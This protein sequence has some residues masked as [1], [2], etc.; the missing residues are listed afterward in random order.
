MPANFKLIGF[1][2][3]KKKEEIYSSIGLKN[4]MKNL[5]L[6]DIHNTAN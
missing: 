5:L 4:N 6:I 1:F 3:M 2:A